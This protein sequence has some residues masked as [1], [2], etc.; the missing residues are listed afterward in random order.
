MFSIL[1]TFDNVD[2]YMI[3]HIILT[4]DYFPKILDIGF[5]TYLHIEYILDRLLK[6]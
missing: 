5:L 2:F 3:D 4:F 1:S 6:T